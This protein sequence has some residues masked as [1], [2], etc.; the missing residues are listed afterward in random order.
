L[1]TDFLAFI[2]ALENEF[3]GTQRARKVD[4]ADRAILLR[5]ET[6]PL[7]DSRG[8]LEELKELARSCNVEVFDTILQHRTQLDPKYLLGK[9]KLADV[10]I[11]A[12]Q[13]GANLLIFDHE[14]TP[15]RFVPWRTL[16]S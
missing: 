5:V 11:K 7:F 3:A 8:S 12:L 16:R 13:M 15:P 4:S 9:G 1:K 14:L 6:N 2:A 10:I